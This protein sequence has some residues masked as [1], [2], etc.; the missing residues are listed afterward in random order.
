[1]ALRRCALGFL[2]LAAT[3]V[4]AEESFYPIIDPNGNVTIIRSERDAEAERS[5]RGTPVQDAGSNASSS[6]AV[7]STGPKSA[8]KMKPSGKDGQPVAPSP[9]FAPYD[10]DEYADVEALDDAVQKKDGK[11]KKRFYVI[12]GDGLGVRNIE[13]DGSSAT[14]GGLMNEG[15]VAAAEKS[16]P[17]V[18]AR[19]ELDSTA[20]QQRWPRLERCQ[21]PGLLE[22]AASI[23]FLPRDLVIDQKTYVFPEAPEVLYAFSLEGQG[24]RRLQV[25]SYS[26]SD[27]APTF[28]LPALALLDREGCLRR[29]VTAYPE[30]SYPE[31][32]SRHPM[33]EGI[34]DVHVE[35]RF[36]LVLSGQPET[37]AATPYRVGRF[38]QL[39]FSL[40][41]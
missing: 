22:K 29:V 35:E 19:A 18:S 23:G 39:M 21:K 20:A 33:L 38:G 28:T 15:T 40:K 25:Q 2:L 36:L 10:S 6:A 37:S 17:L 9:T 14:P 8:Q 26:S 27:R 13:E 1:M 32:N 11:D 7:P 30:R 16:T 34:V 3:P 24:L 41:K 5:K 12:E 31:T 4:V